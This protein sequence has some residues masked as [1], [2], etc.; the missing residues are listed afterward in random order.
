MELGTY[1]PSSGKY[2]TNMDK[3]QSSFV[4][5]NANRC[6]ELCSLFAV[7]GHVFCVGIMPLLQSEL[8]SCL[9]LIS[10]GFLQ[11]F[12]LPLQRYE[13]HYGTIFQAESL[14]LSIPSLLESNR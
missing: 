3:C 10:R 12:V 13:G 11:K 4:L 7:F 5:N 2:G 1:L 9:Y 6:V 8:P 14:H